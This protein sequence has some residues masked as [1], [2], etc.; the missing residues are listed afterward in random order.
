MIRTFWSH[1]QLGTTGGHRRAP[2]CH[3]A[4][5]P[6][7]GLQ[8]HGWLHL[9]FHW[10]KAGKQ[11]WTYLNILKAIYDKHRP[12]LWLRQY[13]ICL[14]CR[15]S[16]FDPW[17]MKIP[18]RKGMATRPSIHA[19]RIPWTKEPVRLQSM[20]SQRFR[21]NWAT[22]TFTF[23]DKHKSWHHSQQW[24][25]ESFSSKIR[26][27]KRMPTLTTFIKHYIRSPSHRKKLSKKKI[28][29]LKT[30]RCWGKNWRWP[31]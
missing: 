13:R 28:C 22:N 26:S 18:L 17:I 2:A 8:L 1:S 11:K 3:D 30:V 9:L 4:S 29:T 21:H 15:W 31:K 14:Q 6:L 10:R 23:H 20:G 25:A 19:W 27:K 12:P 24:K 5:A 7:M 16:K